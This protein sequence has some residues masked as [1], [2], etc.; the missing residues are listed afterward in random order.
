[1]A[2]WST[3]WSGGSWG[4]DEFL[5]TFFDDNRLKDLKGTHKPL[6]HPPLRLL[7]KDRGLFLYPVLLPP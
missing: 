2:K 6:I 1:M 3:N 7:S 5:Q 4:P